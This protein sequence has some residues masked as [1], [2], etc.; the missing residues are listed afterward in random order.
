MTTIIFP[1]FP[2]L[3]I[4]FFCTTFSVEDTN[5]LPVG[6]GRR[7]K[8]PRSRFTF[9]P[10]WQVVRPVLHKKKEDDREREVEVHKKETTIA[11]RGTSRPYGGPSNVSKCPRP[12]RNPL[13]RAFRIRRLGG[14]VHVHGPRPPTVSQSTP[15][16]H[17]GT[18]IHRLWG[19]GSHPSGT[20]RLIGTRPELLGLCTRYQGNPKWR[21]YFKISN[22]ILK[23]LT[24]T[25]GE[26]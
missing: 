25:S 16:T 13:W 4:F 24:V 20:L 2:N 19:Q 10:E 26:T 22:L 3:K 5:T 9:T 11:T 6:L 8:H 18:L 17:T 14:R 12:W 1:S 23:S 7:S 21:F 15:S